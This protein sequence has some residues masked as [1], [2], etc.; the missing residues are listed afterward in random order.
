MM[1]EIVVNA[2]PA[3]RRALGFDESIII[4]GPDCPRGDRF[5]DLSTLLD[6]TAGEFA[7]ATDHHIAL[8]LL[9]ERLTERGGY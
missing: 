2:S 1:A 4:D 9:R 6:A 5:A 7:S 3:R 8:L